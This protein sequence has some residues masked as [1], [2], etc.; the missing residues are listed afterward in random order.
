[1]ALAYVV[2]PISVLAGTT[3]N[4]HASYGV[5]LV[6]MGFLGLASTS[7]LRGELKLGGPLLGFPLLRVRLVIV[8]VTALLGSA[9][10]ALFAIARILALQ[11][12]W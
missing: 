6:G 12:A 2:A 5:M 10:G 7:V 11:N 9:A 3:W 1:M 8:S 4:N